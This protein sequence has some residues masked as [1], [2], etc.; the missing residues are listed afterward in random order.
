L[1]GKRLLD[2]G[3]TGGNNCNTGFVVGD[4]GV[5][6]IDAKLNAESA[7]LMLDAIAKITPSL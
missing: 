3:G 7:K 1:K 4:R 2:A 6:V 5:I